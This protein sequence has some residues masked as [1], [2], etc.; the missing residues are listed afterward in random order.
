M[1]LITTSVTKGGG[2]DKRQQKTNKALASSIYSP[3]E[4]SVIEVRTQIRFYRVHINDWRI[5]PLWNQRGGGGESPFPPLRS[6]VLQIPHPHPRDVLEGRR[7][8]L[9]KKSSSQLSCFLGGHVLHI[10]DGSL[11]YGSQSSPLFGK[12]AMKDNFPFLGLGMCFSYWP[13]G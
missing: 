8:P 4:E 10:S 5:W 2:W 11:L 7:N 3:R 12:W 13:F 1:T 9:F 6:D